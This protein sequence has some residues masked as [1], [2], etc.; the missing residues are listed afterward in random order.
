[1]EI[2]RLMPAKKSSREKT[3]KKSN[4]KRPAAKDFDE[5][6]AAFPKDV[7]QLLRSVRQ[8]IRKAA[9][10]ATE[11]IGYGMPAFRSGRLLVWFA[12]RKN[13]IGFYA[14]AAAIAAFG[15]A[16][17]RYEST[18][19]AVQFPYDEPLPLAL[20]ARMVKYRLNGQQ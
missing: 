1:L 18:K 7:Q 11:T 15:K 4:G 12:A 8:T 16:L 10:K 6:A 3:V 17:S 19:G 13:H 2:E 9:P 20:V 5:Y 14:G